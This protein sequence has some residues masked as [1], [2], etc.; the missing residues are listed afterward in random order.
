MNSRSAADLLLPGLNYLEIRYRVNI[1]LDVRLGRVF[2]YCGP[3]DVK[4]WDV[5][6]PGPEWKRE[7]KGRVKEIIRR[8]KNVP[9][10]F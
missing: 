3:Y 10:L 8:H 9:C 5:A 7:W 1:R 6:D 4:L 2:A